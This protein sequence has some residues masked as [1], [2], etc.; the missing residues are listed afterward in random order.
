MISVFTL[1]FSLSQVSKSSDTCHLFPSIHQ[2]QLRSTP[3]NRKI[4]KKSRPFVQQT[5]KHQKIKSH[6][7]RK[8]H[9]DTTETFGVIHI[10]L[11]VKKKE[12]IIGKSE[13]V[14]T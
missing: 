13:R 2:A 4:K 7:P 9:R 8:T 10:S 14:S 11:S 3:I 1:T 12:K 6:P 5:P